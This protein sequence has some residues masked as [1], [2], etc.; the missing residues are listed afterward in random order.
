MHE[1]RSDDIG[2]GNG[3]PNWDNDRQVS[4]TLIGFLVIAALAVVF[5]VG[6]RDEARIRLLIPVVHTPVW[7]AIA[8]SIA[9]GILLD[10]LF[11]GWWR[12][13]RQR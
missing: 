9:V 13:R 2:S 5:I 6:N 7:V 4:P 10:R 11:L 12:R 3:A 1:Q 8:I